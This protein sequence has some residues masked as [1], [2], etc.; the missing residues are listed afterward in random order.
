MVI[1]PAG[2]SRTCVWLVPLTLKGE[3]TNGKL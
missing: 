3:T 1:Y 2:Y